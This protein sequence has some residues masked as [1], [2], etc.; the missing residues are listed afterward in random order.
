M[1]SGA[2][3][4]A[5]DYFPPGCPKPPHKRATGEYFRLVSRAPTPPDDEFLPQVVDAKGF[6]PHEAPGSRCKRCAF[7]VYESEETARGRIAN[8]GSLF[9]LRHL[10]RM[11]ADKSNGVIRLDEGP[12]GANRGHCLWWIPRGAD[13]RSF[14]R[15]FEE[16]VGVG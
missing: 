3:F 15:F 13:G 5:P 12:L 8:E 11:R 6:R 2:P 7:S 10:A 16:C 9:K 4:D 1:T 14:K